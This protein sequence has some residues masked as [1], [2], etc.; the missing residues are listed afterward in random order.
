M[1]LFDKLKKETKEN[2]KM[3]RENIFYVDYP[4]N[5]S[6]WFQVYSACLGKAMA[7]QDACGQQVVKGQNWS[8]NF[9]KGVIS[10]GKTEYPVQ[11]LG[12]EAD[13]NDSWQW[14]FKNVNG[15]DESLL[16]LVN[17]TKKTGEKWGLEPLTTPAFSLSDTLNGH[18]LSIVAC[19]ISKENYCYY[20]MPHAKGAAF[21][22]FSQVPESVFQ[23]VDLFKFAE[24][25]GE[26]LQQFSIDHKIFVES[27]LMWNGTSYEWIG[28]SIIAHFSKDLVIGFEQVEEF[29]RVSELKTL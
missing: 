29:W 25:T 17:E 18:N 24:I 13:S 1:G 3:E 6:N 9:E 16:K 7:I 12:S 22:A 21:V 11:F 19:G 20:R 26:C 15:F 5:K 10:F 28:N 14:G 8:M 27:F 4:I 23:P 2:S